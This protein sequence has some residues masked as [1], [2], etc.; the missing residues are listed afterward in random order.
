MHKA[1]WHGTLVAVKVLKSS[2]KVALG[3]FKTEINVLQKCHHPHTV[4]INGIV[5][6]AYP[7]WYAVVCRSCSFPGC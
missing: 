6:N 2:S 5:W 3:D 1:M 4:G 7:G